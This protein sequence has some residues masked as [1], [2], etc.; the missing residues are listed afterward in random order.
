VKPRVTMRAALADPDLFGSVLEGESWA[1]GRVLLIALMGEPLTDDER[2]VFASLTGRD[3]E[4]LE[5]VEEFWAVAGRRSGK[6][7]LAAVLAAYIAALCDH[8]AILAL[9]ERAVLPILSA[10]VWQAG[11]AF[12]YIDG[13][14][15]NVPALKALVTGQTADTISLATGVDI[16]CRPASFR[17]I[18]GVTAVAIIA[19]EVAYWRSED[20]SRNPDKEII[21]AARPALASSRGMLVC[22]SSP[23]GKRGELW[24]AYK[25]DYGADGDPRILVAKASSRELNPTLPGSVIARAYER[26]PQ[27]A[28]AEFGG[29]FRNDVSGFLDFAIVDAAVDHG[30]TVRPPVRGV[31]YRSG[32]DPSGGARDSFTLAICHDEA[33]VAVLDCIVEI[34]APFNPTSAT[35]LMAATLKSYRLSQTVGDKYAAEWVV[36]AFAKAGIKYAHADRDR[37]AIYL[38]ALPMFTSGRVWLL[39][40]PRLVSQFASLERRTSPGG[41][42][43]VDHGPAGHDDLCNAVALALVSKS[44]APMFISDAVLAEAARLTRY[45][46]RGRM[47]GF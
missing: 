42:D 13:I 35:A 6:T 33:D 2:A 41:R 45:G 25:R 47:A 31:N 16:E 44:P 3:S 37:S 11:K 4:P 30:V 22:I 43:R 26:D 18:R 24:E 29:E 28:A 15:S 27:A 10:S 38:D 32:S 14:F 39:D 36:D 40:N 19:D 8:S 20:S 5:R 12:Q 21:A 1:P 46:Y 7:R 9:G 17:T 34:R 23:Y